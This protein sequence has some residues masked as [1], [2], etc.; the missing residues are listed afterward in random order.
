M[1]ADDWITSHEDLTKMLSCTESQKVAY[2]GLKLKG[3]AN[4]W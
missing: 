2:A 4:Y 1:M 3:E